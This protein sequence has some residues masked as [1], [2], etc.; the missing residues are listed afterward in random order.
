[1]EKKA[2]A[3][4]VEILTE[5]LNHDRFPDAIVVDNNHVTPLYAS[6]EGENIVYIS[7]D[8]IREL[9]P[10]MPIDYDSIERKL[11]E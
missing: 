1:M 4:R 3:K 7:A 9:H 6:P 5:D 11:N 2:Y 10:D 8:Q